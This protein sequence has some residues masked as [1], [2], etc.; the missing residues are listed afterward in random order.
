M[1]RSDR[2]GR[3]APRLALACALAC[4]PATAAAEDALSLGAFGFAVDRATLYTG[5]LVITVPV[6]IN[7]GQKPRGVGGVGGVARPINVPIDSYFGI[8]DDVTVGI[9]HSRGTINGVGAYPLLRG[10]CLTSGCDFRA[11][12]KGSNLGET[13]TEQRAYDNLAADALY[14]LVAGGAEVA[15]HGG[16]DFNSI[17]DLALAVR[18][19][20]LIKISLGGDM[21]LATDPRVSVYLSRRVENRDQ[22]SAPLALRFLTGAGAHWGLQAG[23]EG[24]LLHFADDF[25][26]WLG[27]FGAIP[28][29]EKIEAFAMLTLPDLF[30]PAGG[31]NARLLVLG[32]NIRP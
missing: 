13:E 15:A 31:I 8:T 7:L 3:R 27:A 24:S 22:L 32:A 14:R 2:P 29:N 21:V 20:S 9:S 23:V 26:G 12:G 19:G 25:L 4:V 18:V 1:N 28:V 16:V 17:F 11:A 6:V 5:D 30:A 10:L